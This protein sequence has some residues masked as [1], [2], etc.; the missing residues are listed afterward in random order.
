MNHNYSG[1]V[2]RY[3]QTFVQKPVVIGPN[4]RIG[5]NV[6]IV[7]R[8]RIGEGAIVGMGTTVSGEIPP[9]AIVAGQKWEVVRHRNREHYERLKR[10]KRF[11][12][13]Q[14]FPSDMTEFPSFPVNRSMPETLEYYSK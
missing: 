13:G 14:R 10:L 6:C 12:G 8:T 11:G 7:P 2:L 4:V 3:D 5:M 9:L 1:E